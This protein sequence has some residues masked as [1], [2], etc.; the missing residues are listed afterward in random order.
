MQAATRV[1]TSTCS[2]DGGALPVRAAGHL[3]IPAGLDQAHERIDGVGKRRRLL[4]LPGHR[5]VV[6][7][8]PVGDQRIPMRGQRGVDLRRLDVRKVIRQ[9][10]DSSSVVLLIDRC[11]SGRRSGSGSA[12]DRPR[13]RIGFGS[14]SDSGR[15]SGSGRGSSLTAVRSW[16]TVAL[17][18][19]CA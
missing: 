18:A 9:Q 5:S 15:G 16:L 6:V 17:A 3:G 2:T 4:A 7:A 1:S 10:V 11:G 13:S 12:R 14:G 19:S 8:L